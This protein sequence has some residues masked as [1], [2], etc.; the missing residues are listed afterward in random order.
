MLKKDIE[1]LQTKAVSFLRRLD[2]I[3]KDLD[4]ILVSLNEG[5]MIFMDKESGVQVSA[6]LVVD[7]AASQV[8]LVEAKHTVGEPTIKFSPSKKAH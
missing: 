4:I 7:T 2:A 3:A 8:S 6:D 1:D 5:K